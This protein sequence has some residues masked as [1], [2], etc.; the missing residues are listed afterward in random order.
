MCINSKGAIRGERKD[1]LFG[2]HV[3]WFWEN[4]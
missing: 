2:M 3:I 4:F 1:N